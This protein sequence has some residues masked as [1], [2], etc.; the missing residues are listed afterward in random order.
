MNLPHLIGIQLFLYAALW[1]LCA[2]ILVSER[3]AVRHY[4]L[5]ALISGVSVLLISWRPVGPV[6]WTHTV[7]SAAGLWGL[8][9]ARRGVEIFLRIKPRDLELG[10]AAVAGLVFLVW[11]GPNDN[12]GR[13]GLS[14]ALSVALM[15]GAVLS[16]WRPLRKEF[17]LR[18]S[19]MASVPISAMLIVNV[20]LG[21]EAL[22]GRVVAAEGAGTQ[23]AVTWTITLISAA[24]FNFLFLFLLGLRMHQSLHR[25][26][27]QDPLT[28]LLNR[29]GMQTQLQS[30]WMRAKRYGLPFSVI[31]LDV[32]HFK[33]I[34]D[35]FGHDAGDR[36]L[37]AVARVL[38]GEVRETDGIA[39]M[40][41]EEFL[42]LMPGTRAEVEGVAL[43]TRLRQVLNSTPVEVEAGLQVTVT[44]SWGVSGILPQDSGA[45]DVLRRADEALYQGK[46]SGRDRVVLF[47]LQDI[48][49]SAGTVRTDAGL[50]PGLRGDAA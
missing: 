13:I 22:Q 14:A 41:G 35:D 9:A 6:W 32:D 4:L 46:R 27:T 26:A 29:R 2:R 34:N 40:G 24:A 15:V 23:Q 30:E 47:G 28:G 48:T 1:A 50:G 8:V 31:S 5:Y 11:I 37:V 3:K 16:C 25:L 36:V 12:L 21:W 43:A 10:L 17:G 20:S 19:L 38:S 33:R 18:F 49:P 7:A 44:A 45:E 39:R 42:V